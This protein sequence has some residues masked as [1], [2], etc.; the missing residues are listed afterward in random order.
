MCRYH[1]G[2]R[3]RGRDQGRGKEDSLGGQGHGL[4]QAGG[5]EDGENRADPAHLEGEIYGTE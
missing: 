1:V 5:G 4:G 2:S 3:W